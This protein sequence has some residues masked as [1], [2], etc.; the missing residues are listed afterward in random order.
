MNYDF[1]MPGQ[2][3]FGWGRRD[4]LPR[5]VLRYSARAWI[6]SGSQTLNSNGVLDDIFAGLK[7]AE[8]EATLLTTIRHEPEVRDVD[9]VTATLLA[10]AP[11]END[12]IIAIG[13]GSAIDLAKAVAAMAKNREGESVA[14]YLEG[15]GRGL[16]IKRAPLPVIAVPTTAGTGSEATKNA[17]LSSYDPPFKKSL[18]S[19]LMV[20]KCVLWDPEL[21]VSCPPHVTAQSGMDAI[22][23][24]IESYISRWAQPIPQALVRSAFAGAMCSI[25]K[26]VAEPGDR[27][28]REQMAFAAFLSGVSLA[29]SGLGLAHGVAAALGSIARVPHGL[30]CAMMLPSAL[31]ANREVKERELGPLARAALHQ[32]TGDDDA[33]AALIERIYELL[34]RL[35]IPRRLSDVGVTEA[36][37]PALVQG[38][39]GNSLS[40]NPRDIS[41]EELMQILKE[42]L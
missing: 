28:A 16:R 20:P 29:N 3:I 36:M 11:A 33:V 6:V 30:A 21:T 17:V 26:A 39:H 4:E 25:E 23:Q 7:L 42:M 14:D 38:S 13:G 2:T 15:V 22:T 5:C 9:D 31:K 34:D 18:R 35:K 1:F 19:E 37:I 40:G 10:S 8:I 24:L 32:L 12:V 41:D 27:S